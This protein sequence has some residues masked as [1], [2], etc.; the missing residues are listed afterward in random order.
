MNTVTSK[1]SDLLHDSEMHSASKIS[2]LIRD[3]EVRSAALFWTMSVLGTALLALIVCLLGITP[4]WS[5]AADVTSV[6]VRYGDLDLSSPAGADAL[7]RR[8]QAAG[9]QV[10]GYSGATL[11]EQAAWRS[12]YRNAV[13]DA[14]R[15]VNSPQ[16]IA[17]QTRN[18]A[19]L[20]AMV[21]K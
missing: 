19:V 2:S 11:L 9:K 16:L 20:M 8:I 18:P 15:K 5:N 7:Y 4:A 3:P 13:G 10:C 14:V 21:V 6:T 1:I 12:C 17:V